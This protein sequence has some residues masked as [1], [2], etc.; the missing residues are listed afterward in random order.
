MWILHI[1]FAMDW[2]VFPQ[3]LYVEGLTLHDHIGE[4]TT[5]VMIKGSWGHKGRAWSDRMGALTGRGRDTGA[6]S[7]TWGHGE[8]EAMWKPGG[9]P[10]QNTKMQAC[11]F[12]TSSLQN[13][14]NKFVV[15][16]IQSV[17][18]VVTAEGDLYN[19]ITL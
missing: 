17:V 9:A 13:W 18:F 19:L 1:I 5:E 10:H 6:L 4:K 14:E 3:N 8:E 7:V 12:Q 2:I 16:A 11:S 15:R